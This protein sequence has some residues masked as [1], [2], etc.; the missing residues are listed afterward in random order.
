MMFKDVY[1]LNYLVFQA[2][3]DPEASHRGFEVTDALAASCV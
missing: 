3:Y 2:F 1:V